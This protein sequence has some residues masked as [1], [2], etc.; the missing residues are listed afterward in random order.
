[1][2]DKSLIQLIEWFRSLP[3]NQRKDKIESMKQFY[4]RNTQEL[5]K[6]MKKLERI[7]HC[8]KEVVDNAKQIVANNMTIVNSLDELLVGVSDAKK[9]VDSQTS[10]TEEDSSGK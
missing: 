6:T 2:D 5:V 1:M 7:E 3:I 10:K 9:T 4:E 8:P